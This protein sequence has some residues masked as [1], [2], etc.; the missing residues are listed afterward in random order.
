LDL[1]GGQSPGNYPICVV[2]KKVAEKK[3]NTQ[4]KKNEKVWLRRCLIWGDFLLI[5]RLSF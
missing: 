4:E 3:S 2:E 5:K 1:G